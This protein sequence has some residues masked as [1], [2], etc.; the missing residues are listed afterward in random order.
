M[1]RQNKKLCML[2]AAAAALLMMAGCGAKNDGAAFEMGQSDLEYVQ[3][4]G[5][6]TV[7]ITDFAPMDYK[8]G[9][10]WIGFDAKLAEAFAESLGVTLELKEIDW[11]KKTNLL[12]DGSIDCI[13][14][15]MTMT[16][17][18]QET[19]SCSDPYLSN[20]Q[21]IVLRSGEMEQYNT[22]E[23]CQHLL[24][25]VEAGSTGENL[26]KELKYRYV[27]Y[28]TQ[29]EALQSVREKKADATVIDIIMASYYTDKGQEFD[30]LGFHDSLNDERIC[31]GFRKNSD[32]TEKADDF[33][34]SA[35]EDGTVHALAEK[36]GIESAV[37]N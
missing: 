34:K 4:K 35:Y 7:G 31:V 9:E 30:D 14:N 25:A 36:Y 17:E 20:A 28:S 11:D 6:L 32:L 37:L 10:E 13:W 26:L 21:V 19:I 29:M 16:E 23:A 27:T 1:A 22:V 5:T 2:F 24:F 18:L 12:E 33:L 8:D 3:S 15:G